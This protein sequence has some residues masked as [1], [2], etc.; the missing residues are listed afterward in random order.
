M[1]F[2]E[3]VFKH[4]IAELNNDLASNFES[5]KALLELPITRSGKTLRKEKLQTE[6]L[7]EKLAAFYDVCRSLREHIPIHTPTSSQVKLPSELISDMTAFLEDILDKK[8]TMPR[9]DA[10]NLVPLIDSLLKISKLY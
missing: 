7:F 10:F 6:Q 8:E 1:S 4:S 5:I 3:N 2:P 9:L